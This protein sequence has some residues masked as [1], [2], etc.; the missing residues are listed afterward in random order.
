[1]GPDLLQPHYHLCPGHNAIRIYEEDVGQYVPSVPK[2]MRS[3]DPQTCHTT[4]KPINMA[5][6]PDSSKAS[7]NDEPTDAHLSGWPLWSLLLGLLL[8]VLIVTL[9]I[10]IVAVAIPSITDDFNTLKDIAWYASAFLICQCTL[11]PLAGRTYTYFP[12][13]V[14]FMSFLL[15]FEV[16]SLLCGVA[17]SST[18][19][20][21][22]RAV[23]G[24]G[25]S[26]LING[27]LAIVNIATPPGKKSIAMGMFMAVASLGQVIGPLIGGGLTDHASWRWCFYIN[28][29]IGGAAVAAFIFI[30]LPPTEKKTWTSKTLFWDLDIP[31]FAIFAPASI[32]LLLGLN[33]GGNQYPW[34]S[35]TVIGLLCGAFG[36]SVIFIL[37][38]IRQQDRAMIPPPLVK[39]RPFYTSCITAFVQGGYMLVLIYYIVLW[40]QVIKYASPTM[41]GVYTLP[42]FLSQVLFAGVT[43]F[44]GMCSISR[45]HTPK[46]TLPLQSPNSV[47]PSRPSS[48]VTSWASSPTAS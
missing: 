26:G 38:E 2:R 4:S 43:G 12:F 36:T 10:S 23:C 9:D 21:I 1:M 46:L 35:A 31:G 28:L 27:A 20:V 42:S 30:R 22:G 48:W 29:P 8:V 14:C 40:F 34:S 47:T 11:I 6:E 44:A 24:L 15:I 39:L 32:M 33:W 5:P 37:W 41:S 25:S 7:S 3:I 18:M 19:L 13:K 45:Y 17:T 16:G